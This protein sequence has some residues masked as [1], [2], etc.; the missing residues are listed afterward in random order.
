MRA[1]FQTEQDHF[2]LFL[3]ET[4]QV[5]SRNGLDLTCAC[6][7]EKKT[8][9]GNT[10]MLALDTTSLAYHGNEIFNRSSSLP[11]VLFVQERNRVIIQSEIHENM[12]LS[13]N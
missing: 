1:D 4:N 6:L 8:A 13:A 12:V 2:R 3:S 7:L 5:L 11:Y 10:A 9:Q